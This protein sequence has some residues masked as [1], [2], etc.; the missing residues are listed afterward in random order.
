MN[1]IVIEDKELCVGCNACGDICPKNAIR[2]KGDDEGFSYP[3]VDSSKCVDCGLCRNTCPIIHVDEIRKSNTQ[4]EPEVLAGINQDLNVR[5]DSTSGGIFSALADVVFAAGGFVGGAIWNDDFSISQVVTDKAEELPK[6]RSSKYAQ[7]DAQGFYR[8]VKNAIKTGR[9]VLVCGTPCQMVALRTY[10]GKQYSNL[11]I[12]DF[13]CRGINSPKILSEYLK[14]HERLKGAKIVAIK[15]KNKELGWRR[16]T[17]KL[18]FETG[19]VVY[20]PRETSPYMQGYLT[21]NMYSRP[22]CYVCKFKGFP[23][24]ADLTLA[25]CWGAVNQLNGELD[26]D[27]GTSLVLVNTE[28]GRKAIEWVEHTTTLVRTSF[29]DALEGNKMLVDSLSRPTKDRNLYFKILRE[30][31]FEKAAEYLLTSGT[32]KCSIK[33]L[34]KKLLRQTKKI[35]KVRK[36]LIQVIRQNGLLNILKGTPS[37]YMH[38]KFVWEMHKGANV[39][40]EK[41]DV[42]IGQSFVFKKSSLESR[43]LVSSGA[44]LCLHGGTISYGCDIELFKDASLTIGENALMNIGATIICANKITLGDGVTLGRNVTIRDTHGGH[45]INRSDFKT[46]APIE[47]GD[48]V[49][50]CDD[51]IVMP[52][53]KIGAGSVVAAR[54]LVTKDV[55]PNTLVAGSPAQVIRQNVEWKR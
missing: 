26:G 6:L 22:S 3:V 44:T 28:Q 20:D 12:V 49:W 8:A 25:D 5:F 24:M 15:Q 33:S 13:I 17:T 53:V 41:T 7:S 36:N 42:N 45:F 14:M 27:L 21:A 31:G 2:F 34:I 46:T 11:L 43:V 30:E 48:H 9:Q 1:R 10:L 18:T 55:P 39:R 54:S 23:R 51:V 47:I 32:S 4:R 35:L 16:L 37:V 29:S 52:G 38:G 19:D 50:L 40:V